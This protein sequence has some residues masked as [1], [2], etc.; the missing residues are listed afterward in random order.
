MNQPISFVSLSK[1][2]SQTIGTSPHPNH[3][4]ANI[5][6]NPPFLAHCEQTYQWPVVC[7]A[8]VHPSP[9]RTYL[10]TITRSA[11][12]QLGTTRDMT[13]VVRANAFRNTFEC[14]GYRVRVQK[15]WDSTYHLARGPP[16]TNRDRV[17]QE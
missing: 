2:R 5:F 13:F 12:S 7:T 8:V 6:A 9:P 11:A 4:M 17:Y 1:L 10:A 16:C 14:L 15:I 3:R